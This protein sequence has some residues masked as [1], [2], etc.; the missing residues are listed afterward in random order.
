MSAGVF[1]LSA[2]LENYLPKHVFSIDTSQKMPYD[3]YAK[4]AF[5]FSI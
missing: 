3:D 2:V 4:S 1:R 5:R